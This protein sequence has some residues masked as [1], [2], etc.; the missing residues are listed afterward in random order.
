MLPA[1]EIRSPSAF[2]GG[3]I[4]I[5]VVKRRYR[6]LTRRGERQELPP[7]TFPVAT[8]RQVL[9][10]HQDDT[11]E[12]VVTSS[13]LNASRTAHLSPK[14]WLGFLYGERNR[15]ASGFLP[16]HSPDPVAL[17]APSSA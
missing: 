6:R 17:L 12:Y 9:A 4:P 15:P 1:S 16:S 10:G 8:C 14:L 2:A 7:G 13:R 3:D 11:S 5:T